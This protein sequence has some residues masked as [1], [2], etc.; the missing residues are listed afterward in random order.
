MNTERSTGSF[1]SSE[2]GNSKNKTN[3]FEVSLNKIENSFLHEICKDL[4]P[5]ELEIPGLNMTVLLPSDPEENK[6]IL[7]GVKQTEYELL[8][9]SRQQKDCRF[10]PCQG[11]HVFFSDVCSTCER[12][13]EP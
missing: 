11:R 10:D 1:G 3:S 13:S 8:L 7:Q 9:T 4:Q 5:S 12:K 6:K 2:Q